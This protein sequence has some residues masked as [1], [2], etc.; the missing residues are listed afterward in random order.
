ML[1]GTRSFSCDPRSTNLPQAV[2]M[3][4]FLEA[5]DRLWTRPFVALA[6]RLPRTNARVQKTLGRTQTV[7][8]FRNSD[9]RTSDFGECGD[10]CSKHISYMCSKHIAFLNINS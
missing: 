3:Y 8:L 7:C 5:L 9:L 4:L 2:E 6:A 10:M 1:I